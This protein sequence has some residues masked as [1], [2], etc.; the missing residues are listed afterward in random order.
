MN[1]N[2]KL[3]TEGITKLGLK[4]D[5]AK[6]S[7]LLQ[8]MAIL[9]KWN[10]VYSLTSITKDD[11]II[12]FHLLDGLTVIPHLMDICSIIDVGSGMGVPGIVI[13]IWCPE[14]KVT[15][16]DCN[17][18]KTAFLQQVIIELNLSNVKVVCN[19]VENYFPESKYEYAI[20]RAFGNSRMFIDKTKH[21]VKKAFMLMKSQK[22]QEELIDVS[23]FQYEIF[24]LTLPFNQD[25]RYLLKIEI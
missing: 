5:Q 2:I 6:I 18:K 8:F 20:S 3:L 9:K 21:L 11:K 7:L 4:V 23:G 10:K 16:I 24:T 13:A 15:L 25:K 17:H 1:D 14:K 12:E 22:I 19:T